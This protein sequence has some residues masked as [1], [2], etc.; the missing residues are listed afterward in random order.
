MHTV[1]IKSIALV[2]LLVLYFGK[3]ALVHIFEFNCAESF[4]TIYILI[5][6]YSCFVISVML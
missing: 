6:S 3:F 5:Y 2:L 1:M 4:N